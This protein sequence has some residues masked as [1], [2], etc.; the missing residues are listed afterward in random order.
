MKAQWSKDDDSYRLK[1]LEGRFWYFLPMHLPM[2]EVSF[3]LVTSCDRTAI[4]H[5]GV[6]ATYRARGLV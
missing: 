4:Q 2:Q 5:W 6:N 3:M 1:R